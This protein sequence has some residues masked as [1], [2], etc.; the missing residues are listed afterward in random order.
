MYVA[1]D[2]RCLQEIGWGQC[3][4]LLIP[5]RVAFSYSSFIEEAATSHPGFSRSEW[6]CFCMYLSPGF[7][8]VLRNPPLPWRD[9]LGWGSKYLCLSQILSSEIKVSSLLDVHPA[10]QWSSL[11]NSPML[12]SNFCLSI[13][14]MCSESAG[15]L[16]FSVSHLFYRLPGVME[17]S[18]EALRMLSLGSKIWE[19]RAGRFRKLK[20]FWSCYF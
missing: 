1:I 19:K 20:L 4:H 12:L 11:R 13:E 17:G 7:C 16:Q 3:S 6:I 8:T 14:K 9:K 2:Q 18:L 10:S 15:A 5:P